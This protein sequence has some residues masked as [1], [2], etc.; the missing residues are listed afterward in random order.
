MIMYRLY[1]TAAKFIVPRN[2]TR[3]E[4]ASVFNEKETISHVLVIKNVSIKGKQEAGRE[5]LIFK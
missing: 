5:K 3:D 1:A 2:L 4:N